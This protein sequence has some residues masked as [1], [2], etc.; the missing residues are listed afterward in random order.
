M[1]CDVPALHAA[2]MKAAAAK[3]SGF[4]GYS[5]CWI[6][7]LLDVRRWIA[8]SAALPGMLA[9]PQPA[10]ATLANRATLAGASRTR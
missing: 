4:T 2:R 9:P 6:G 3:A 8:G 10:N 5:A 1:P 7:K